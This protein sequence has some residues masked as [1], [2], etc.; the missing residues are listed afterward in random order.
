[1]RITFVFFYFKRYTTSMHIYACFIEEKVCMI[2]AWP[3]KSGT[4]IVPKCGEFK[5]YV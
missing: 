1:M 4:E 3:G 5:V 2:S